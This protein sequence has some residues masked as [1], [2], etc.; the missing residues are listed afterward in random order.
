MPERLK[1][2][3]DEAAAGVEPR[4]ADPIGLVVRR[5]RAGRVR[6]GAAG[7]LALA[8]LLTG[9]FVGGQRLLADPAQETGTGTGVV[10]SR[11]ER[12]PTPEHVDGR[13]VAGTVSFPVPEG[14]PVL[15]TEGAPCGHQKRTVL[16]GEGPNPYGPSP[17]CTTADIEVHSLFDFYPYRYDTHDQNG[18]GMVTGLLASP[19]R[20]LTLH[21]GEPVWLREDPDGARLIVLPWSRVAVT[22]RGGVEV[23]QQVLNSITTGRWE[24]AALTLP[25]QV[26]EVSMMVAGEDKQSLRLIRDPAQ[27]QRAVELLR[28]GT[29]VDEPEFCTGEMQMTKGLITIQPREP[30]PADPV[31]GRRPSTLVVTLGRDCHEVVSEEGGRVRLDAEAIAELGDI[32]GVRLSW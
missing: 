16:I 1:A 10:A 23:W 26:E 8:V 3:L 28:A 4:T 15:Q 9:G 22:V 17:W 29:V 11:P 19:T 32:L 31:A 20:M 13:I 21:G 12:P 30:A 24:P 25:R 5:G 18:P 6:A 7:A 27:V 2:L 14:W